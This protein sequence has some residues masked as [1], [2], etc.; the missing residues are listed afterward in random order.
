MGD[1]G[2]ISGQ[3]LHANYNFRYGD[4]VVV[5]PGGFLS[6][7]WYE[8]GGIIEKGLSPPP[9]LLEALSKS[10]PILSWSYIEGLVAEPLHVAEPVKV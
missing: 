7:Q 9:D 4:T 10:M 8:D 3:V 6:E 1:P 5:E 2:R